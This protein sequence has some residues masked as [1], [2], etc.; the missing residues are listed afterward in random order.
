[1][2]INKYLV[3]E[4]ELNNIEMLLQL[5]KN[6]INSM[7]GCYGSVNEILKKTEELDQ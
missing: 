4:D 2:K 5:C 7:Y 3:W 1:M 6:E